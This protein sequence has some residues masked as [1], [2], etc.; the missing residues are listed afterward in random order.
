MF[1]S[2]FFR[3]FV[4]ILFA[5]S[6]RRLG[7]LGGSFIALGRYWISASAGMTE[8]MARRAEMGGGHPSFEDWGTGLIAFG[9]WGVR[10]ND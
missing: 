4:A 1:G 5:L 3:F 8:G 9:G 10:G 7:L 6:R 2:P